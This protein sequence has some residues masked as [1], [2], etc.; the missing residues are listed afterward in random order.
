MDLSKLFPCLVAWAATLAGTGPRAFQ[1]LFPCFFCKIE[2]KICWQTLGSCNILFCVQTHGVH[3]DSPIL[4]MNVLIFKLL[5][6]LVYILKHKAS[7]FPVVYR[8]GCRIVDVGPKRS[9]NRFSTIRDAKICG[10]GAGLWSITHIWLVIIECVRLVDV[11]FE[12]P[13][14][15]ADLG[16]HPGVTICLLRQ[17]ICEQMEVLNCIQIFWWYSLLLQSSDS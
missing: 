13:P 4:R 8:S 7:P 10:E 12:H 11:E 1:C 16:R 5:K 14:T 3:C 6:G 9:G 17:V 2:I 15:F